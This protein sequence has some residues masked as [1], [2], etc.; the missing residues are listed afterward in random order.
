[1]DQTVSPVPQHR[2]HMRA[3]VYRCAHSSMRRL[4]QLWDGSVWRPKAGSA[5]LHEHKQKRQRLLRL[6]VAAAHQATVVLPVSPQLSGHVVH[7]QH[8]EERDYKGSHAFPSNITRDYPPITRDCP[9]SLLT[10]QGR[11]LTARCPV[12]VEPRQAPRLALLRRAVAPCHRV[13]SHLTARRAKCHASHSIDGAGRV[14]GHR[15]G[16]WASYEMIARR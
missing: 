4:A 3:R 8:C 5:M 11:S 13:L 1:M 14:S 6:R 12:V 2:Q 9:P 10:S 7:A 16:A 15:L